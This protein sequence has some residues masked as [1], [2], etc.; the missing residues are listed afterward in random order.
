MKYKKNFEIFYW[1]GIIIFFAGG[2]LLNFQFA[3]DY[4]I[5]KNLMGFLFCI[6]LSIYYIYK[7]KEFEFSIFVYLPL[8]FFAWILISAFYAPFKFESAKSLENYILYFLIFIISSNLK[9]DKKIFYVWITSGIIASIIGIFQFYGPRHYP[10]STFGNPNF[11]AG[12]IIMVLSLTLSNI[13]NYKEY[14]NE[15]LGKFFSYIDILSLFFC[16]WGLILTNSRAAI[17]AFILTIPFMLYLN[18]LEKKGILK[19]VGLLITVFF[20]ILYYPKILLWYRTNIRFYIWQGTWK[21]IIKKPIL[22]WGLGNFIFY[23]PYFRIKEYFLQPESRNVTNHPHNEY[24][25]IWSETGLI[26]F[27][28]F[29]SLILFLIINFIKKKESNKLLFVGIIGGI[30]SVLLDNIFSTNM[31]NPSTSMYFWFLIGITFQ[32]F[33]R[34]KVPFEVSQLIWYII[35]LTSVVLFIFHSFYRILPQVYF[36]MS[37]SIKEL[38]SYEEKMGRKIYEDSFRIKLYKECIENYHKA[39]ALNPNDYEIWYKLAY[40]YGKVGDYKKARDIYLKINNYLFPHYAKTDANLGTIYIKM[41][42]F[43]KALQYY[44]IA[45]WFNPY[46]VDLL[47]SIASIYI[48]YYNNIESALNYIKRVLNL[49]PKNKYANITILKL[50]EEGKLK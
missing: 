5:I 46:D 47:C 8:I 44:K 19:Y 12:H 42:N 21:L 16:L 49:D 36:K 18:N 2:I 22:G 31:R 7:R 27:L 28:I 14:K 35:F 20:I 23:Y 10:I 48:I 40:M 17:M 9:I 38:I 6:F 1:T 45:E 39:C 30:I 41:G 32:Y 50:K 26:G 13:L 24:L 37:E 43:E 25:E 33:K 34:E 3:Y 15:K 11:Y 29:L 4:T